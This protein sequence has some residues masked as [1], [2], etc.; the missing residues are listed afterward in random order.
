MMQAKATLMPDGTVPMEV[1][2]FLVS[3]RNHP[4]LKRDFPDVSVSSIRPSGATSRNLA[5]ADFSIICKPTGPARLIKAAGGD[6][7]KKEAK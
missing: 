6:K 2:D 3:L 1:G 7:A 4:M 5:S